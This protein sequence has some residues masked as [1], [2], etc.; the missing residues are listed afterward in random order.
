MY[1][2]LDNTYEG[3]KGVGN[4]LPSLLLFFPGSAG[5]RMSNGDEFHRTPSPVH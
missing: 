3:T 2:N 1:K 5:A 4:K